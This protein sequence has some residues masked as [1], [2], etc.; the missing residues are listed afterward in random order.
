MTVSNWFKVRLA[1]NRN[2]FVIQVLRWAGVSQRFCAVCGLGWLL[3][4]KLHEFGVCPFYF[5]LFLN[6]T[7]CCLNREKE[8]GMG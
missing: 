2:I 1:A 5:W 8:A 6:F 4:V 7:C 3:T